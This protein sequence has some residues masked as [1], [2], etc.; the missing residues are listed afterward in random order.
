MSTHRVLSEVTIKVLETEDGKYKGQVVEPNGE[1]TNTVAN[2][3]K[4]LAIGHAFG[5]A[6]VIL[7]SN[8]KVSVPLRSE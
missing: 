1:K 2:K 3:S 7:R 5:E 6:K 8:N 4:D